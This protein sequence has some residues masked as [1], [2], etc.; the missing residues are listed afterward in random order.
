MIIFRKNYLVLLLLVKNKFNYEVSVIKL[1]KTINLKRSVDSGRQ[2]S[3][4][5]YKY[6]LIFYKLNNR[7]VSMLQKS[8]LKIF[9]RPRV[10]FQNRDRISFLLNNIEMKTARLLR[11][12]KFC[13]TFIYGFY[14]ASR[15]EFM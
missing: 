6:D 9:S 12:K 13:A 2:A 14:C 7:K 3:E 5:I 1:S 15:P 11:N 8:C 4:F 10:S